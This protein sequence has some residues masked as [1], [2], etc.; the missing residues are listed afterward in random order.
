MLF[1][2]ETRP[3]CL[4]S[5]ANT[6]PMTIV[7]NSITHEEDS[8]CV[9][10]QTCQE[11]FPFN[12]IQMSSSALRSGSMSRIG[13]SLHDVFHRIENPNASAQYRLVWVWG[14]HRAVPSQRKGGQ[15]KLQTDLCAREAVLACRLHR[16]LRPSDGGLNIIT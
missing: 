15:R 8:G 7:I 4:G 3:P 1:S 5:I 13:T 16:A 9:Q 6:P 12:S 11:T 10:R 14:G 2:F